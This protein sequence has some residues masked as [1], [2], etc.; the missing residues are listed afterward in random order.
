VRSFAPRRSDLRALVRLALPVAVVQ[1]TMMLMGTVD[2]VM[3]GRVSPTDLAAV[4]LGNLYFF[5]V[6]VFGM[7][8]LFAL[9]P[10]ISQAVGADDAVGVARGVQRGAVLSLALSVLAAL[11]LLP[12][13][14]VLSTLG[15]PDDVVPV[16]AGYARACIPGVLPFYL[17]NV[18]RQSLQAMHRMRPILVTVVAANLAN[19]FFNWVLIYGNLGAPALGAV[20]SGWATSL[21]RTFMTLCLLGLGWPLLRSSVRPLRRDAIA[22]A[23]LKRFLRL[24]TPI[25]AQQMLEFGVFGAAGLLMGWMGTVPMA[26]HQVALNLAS[27]TFM[28]SVGAAQASSVLVGHAVGRGDPHG[29]RRAAGAGLVA[30]AGFMACAAALFLSVP[31]ELARL[32]TDDAGVVAV[33]AV[34]IPI[35]GI[36]QVFDGI[37]VVSSGVLRGVGDTRLPMLLNLLG[38]WGVGL[39]VSVVL[40][41]GLHLGP[42]GV[43]LGLASG[44]GAVALLLLVRVRARFGRDLRRVVMDDEHE[45]ASPAAVP[46]A[47]T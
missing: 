19:A 28:V 15:Q 39:P 4:A 20:G 16:A 24:G 40:G 34:L 36:F 25:G 46:E 9:D 43:W 13:G 29:A 23:P 45:A 6:V 5:G 37:Q 31:D 42:R 47:A 38:F 41:F 3:V 30:G 17:F 14:A 32:Y 35:A 18:L 21:S 1:V 44:I 33:A 27:L 22:R 8:V 12:A 26:S 7:G 10:V 11:L 2:T